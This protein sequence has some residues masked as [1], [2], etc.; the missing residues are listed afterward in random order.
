MNMDS[1]VMF[2]IYFSTRSKNFLIYYHI[3]LCFETKGSF[4][5]NNIT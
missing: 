5:R 2:V 4:I 3:K 1:F